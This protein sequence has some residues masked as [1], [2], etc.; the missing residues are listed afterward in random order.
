MIEKIE[1]VATSIKI[2]PD[3]WKKAKIEAIKEDMELSQ[4]VEKALEAWMRDHR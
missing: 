1:R 4:L 3:I 2:N